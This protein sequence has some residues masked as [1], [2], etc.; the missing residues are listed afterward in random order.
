[1]SINDLINR[2]GKQERDLFN[3]EIFSPYFPGMGTVITRIAGIIYRF[4]ISKQD[5]VGF[6]IFKPK[7]PKFAH[8][9]REANEEQIESYLNLLPRVK[10]ILVFK[11]DF[12]YCI[13]QNTSAY[14]K[15]GFTGLCKA[16]NADNIES[17]D[18]F[19]GR[20]DGQH[21]WF[22]CLDPNCD[23]E[24]IESLKE[25]SKTDSL[26]QIKGL[27]PE[28]KSVFEMIK[29]NREE[30]IALTLEG[31]LKSTL[32]RKGA[33]LDNYRERNDQIEVKWKTRSGEPYTTWIR[34]K[35]FGV[36]SAGI[37]LEGEDEKF[38]L[39]S[40]IGVVDQGEHISAIFRTNH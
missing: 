3:Q 24:K 12:W 10:G 14:T 1:M 38:D 31:R 37:C 9:R 27:T 34:K 11:T 21:V 20:F 32:E 18:Y 23:F 16:L 29:K 33:V 26:G 28:D 15:I 22:E 19:V 40:L 4:K 39:S 8:F 35:D 6:G 13:S 36:I 2:L 17:F 30:Q 5:K 25:K 7:N